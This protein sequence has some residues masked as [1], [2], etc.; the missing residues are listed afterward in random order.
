VINILKSVSYKYKTT[1]KMGR[2]KKSSKRLVF[3]EF[4]AK[5]KFFTINKPTNG[6]NYSFPNFI[7]NLQFLKIVKQML[8]LAIIMNQMKAWKL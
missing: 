1:L 2:F 4:F 6:Q 3:K 8:K 7:T 5:I